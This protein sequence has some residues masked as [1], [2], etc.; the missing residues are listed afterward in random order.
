MTLRMSQRQEPLA[1]WLYRESALRLAVYGRLVLKT[2]HALT[3]WS[4]F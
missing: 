1:S 2:V 4:R 3:S